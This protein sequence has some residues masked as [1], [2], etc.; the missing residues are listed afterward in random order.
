MGL[1]RNQVTR[2]FKTLGLLSDLALVGGAAARVVQRRN[3][4]ATR[5]PSIV[6]LA[7]AGGA[8]VRL[9]RRFGRRRR[10]RR[11]VADDAVD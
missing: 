4:T 1:L 10:N 9:L 6:E 2:R 5:D 3:G 11:A 8:A 7:L